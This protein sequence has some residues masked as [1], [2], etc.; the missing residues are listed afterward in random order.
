MNQ[1]IPSLP[2]PKIMVNA[3]ISDSLPSFL[4]FPDSDSQDVHS[5][6]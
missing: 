1:D 2:T 3:I 6:M 5:R 4:K